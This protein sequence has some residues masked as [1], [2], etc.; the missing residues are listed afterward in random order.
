MISSTSAI[1]SYLT[2]VKY[3]LMVPGILLRDKNDIDQ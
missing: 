3:M 2:M 1:P